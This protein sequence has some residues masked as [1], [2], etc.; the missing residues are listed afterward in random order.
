MLGWARVI[1][2]R[3]KPST[4]NGNN[5]TGTQVHLARTARTWYSGKLRMCAG[6]R[7]IGNVA[8]FQAGSIIRGN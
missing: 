8:M 7:A 2:H 1:T 6:Q 4:A 3:R 5:K